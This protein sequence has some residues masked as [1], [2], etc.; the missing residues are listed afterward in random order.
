LPPGDGRSLDLSQLRLNE[1]TAIGDMFEHLLPRQ[2]SLSAYVTAEQEIGA[3]TLFIDGAFAHR[4]SV[5]SQGNATDFLFVP[6][7]N[8]YSAFDEDVIVG[9]S[10]PD[11]GDVRFDVEKDGWFVNLGARGALGSSSWTWE[12]VGT[13][14]R[15][16][17]ETSLDDLDRED[18]AL[19]LASDDPALA[20]NPFG[21]GSGQAPGV[22][23]AIRG[24][25]VFAG[26]TTLRSVAV[27]AQGSL[28][29]LPGGVMRL[30]LGS[31]YREE[32]M[33]SS[34]RPTGA[35]ELELYPGA[36]R[37]VG[38]LF[39]ELYV[40]LVGE[41][42]ERAGAQQLALSAA[43]RYEDYSDFGD[44]INPKLGILWRPTPDLA[45]KA[46]WGTSFRAPSLRELT[47]L[48]FVSSDLFVLDPNAPGGPA[49]VFAD[50]IEG[51]N[52]DLREETAK[53]YTISAEYTPARLEGLHFSLTRF[54]IDYEDRIRGSLDGIDVNTL[55]Q[56]ESVLP[57]GTI[58]RAPNGTLEVINV[59]N[60]N[61]AHTI[62]SGYDAAAG[63]YWS[64]QRWGSFDL[65]ASTTFISRYDDQLISGSRVL[66]FAGRVGSTPDWRGSIGLVW[67]S[68]PW[69]TAVFVHHTDGL[70]N[71]D[72][73]PRIVRRTVA[74][75]T[76]TDLQL[77]YTSR[78][79]GSWLHG[80]TARLGAT[81]LFDERPPFVDG[82]QRFG[83]DIQNSSVRG[84]TIYLRLSKGFGAA[85]LQ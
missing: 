40:P 18:L 25:T 62:M 22:I 80:F 34:A 15:D 26:R 55:L 42:S 24:Q 4:T 48:S 29:Q 32:E 8:A 12:A 33:H 43:A 17:S 38:A 50:V 13:Q 9:Y 85:R 28:W 60:I 23:D 47:F 37:D 74:S 82:P 65:S 39:G 1:V 77:S 41:A 52:R 30:A 68:G 53:T 49:D 46:N 70:R 6:A 67:S 44:T 10:F 79:G 20:F 72:I 58:V 84:R 3:T 16:E 36:T 27:Q 64:T 66:D 69:S 59:T 21:D 31:E 19:R 73:D 71:E 54:H 5:F 7:T 35:G 45:L 11:F 83:L 51:G 61:S 76:I 81:N 2:E 78:S 57:E 56:F 75:Q 14:A 63:H